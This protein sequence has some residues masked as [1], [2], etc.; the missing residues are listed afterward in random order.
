MPQLAMITCS[1]MRRGLIVV[2]WSSLTACSNAVTPAAPP[3][4]PATSVAAAPR[5]HDSDGVPDPADR[6]PA[7]AGLAPHGCPDP[8]SD[9]DGHRDSEDRCPDEPGE[10]DGCPVRDTDGDTILDPD[11]RCVSALETRNGFTDGDGCP[12]ELPADLAAITGKIEGLTFDLNKDTIKPRSRPVLE[13]YIEVLGKYPD[14]HVEITGH[15]D[16]TAQIQRSDLSSRRAAAVMRYLVQHG[17]LAARIQARGAGP[18]EPVDTNKTAA[19]RARNRRVEL[20][21]L[22]Q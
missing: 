10:P 11:D 7:V 16:A 14:V 9:G 13:R 21:I 22:V 12:D 18:D 20:T 15:T 17:I 2:V 1:Q 5:D 19:G 3:A 8:D 6:C 4:L